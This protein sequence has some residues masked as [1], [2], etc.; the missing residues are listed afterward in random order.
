MKCGKH[1]AKNLWP[2]GL[3]IIPNT[4][5]GPHQ[6]CGL[7]LGHHSSE[8]PVSVQS[9]LMNGREKKKSSSSNTVT[10]QM[11]NYHWY[12]VTKR[13]FSERLET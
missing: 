8:E 6:L 13:H 2:L 11:I 1:V 7:L 10:L 3:I 4:L 9:F 5:Q 12:H